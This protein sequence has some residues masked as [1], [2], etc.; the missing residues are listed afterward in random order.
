[1]RKTFG[2]RQHGYEKRGEGRGG[3][4]LVGGLPLDRHVLPQLLDK[5]QLV[6]ESYKHRNPAQRSHGTLRLAQNQ[7]LLRQQGADLARDWIVRCLWF[8]SPVVS[9]VYEK[10]KRGAS[11]FRLN[12]PAGPVQSVK[13]WFESLGFVGHLGIGCTFV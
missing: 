1:M 6:K 12:G 13:V 5:S 8:H 11:E 9:D 2:S 10:T 3:I 7:P 4:D